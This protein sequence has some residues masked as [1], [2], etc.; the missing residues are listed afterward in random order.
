MIFPIRSTS[1]ASVYSLNIDKTPPNMCSTCYLRV[2]Q[3]LIHLSVFSML[4]NHW[5]S[6]VYL[7]RHWVSCSE[8]MQLF[9]HF[10]NT[11]LT[12]KIYH[13][14][15]TDPSWLGTQHWEGWRHIEKAE[16]CRMESM[17]PDNQRGPKSLLKPRKQQ[18]EE[19]EEKSHRLG[20]D[21]CS[22]YAW[23]KTN[24]QNV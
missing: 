19:C 23:Y 6:Y 13:C 5:F 16:K 11:G 20:R 12:G 15:I 14:L 3:L 21:I 9:N 17:V 18:H 4:F 10:G 22:S 8:R 2:N 1:V 24:T 7:S